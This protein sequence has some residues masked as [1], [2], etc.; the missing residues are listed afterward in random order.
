MSLTFLLTYRGENGRALQFVDAMEQSGLA[1]TIRQRSGNLRYDYFISH[2]NPEEVLLVDTWTDQAAL[3]AHHASPEMAQ[4]I[5]LRETY[6]LHMT[7]QRLVS[8]A[9]NFSDHDK[10]FIRD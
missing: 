10:S 9:S 8:D 4:I 2:A 5:A 1:T 7:A 3:D 6:D